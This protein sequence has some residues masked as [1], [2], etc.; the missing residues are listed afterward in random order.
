MGLIGSARMP[1]TGGPFMAGPQDL[2]KPF[3]P[4][5]SNIDTSYAGDRVNVTANVPGAPDNTSSYKQLGALMGGLQPAGKKKML[6]SKGNAPIV[7]TR[8]E[9][10]VP[11]SQPMSW[12]QLQGSATKPTGF[13]P[14]MIPGMAVSQNSLPPWMRAQ[15]SQFQ[16]ASS[17]GG[18][19]SSYAGPSQSAP[20]MPGDDGPSAEERWFKQFGSVPPWMQQQKG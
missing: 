14:Q 17:S 13:G 4:G 9:T 19:G 5:P 6:G 16:G 1:G 2:F 10:R 18:A 15:Q 3:T 20:A 12:Q 11:E 7:A 8:R